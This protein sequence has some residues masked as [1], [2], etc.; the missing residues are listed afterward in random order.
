MY[1]HIYIAIVKGGYQ[2]KGEGQNVR[3]GKLRC[4]GGA[5]RRKEKAEVM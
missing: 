4:I 1:M 5:R 3:V 2:Y